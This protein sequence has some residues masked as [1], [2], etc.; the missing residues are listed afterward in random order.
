MSMVTSGKKEPARASR[1][2]IGRPLASR[3]TPGHHSAVGRSGSH[4]SEVQGYSYRHSTIVSVTTMRVTGK[5]AKV[6][7]TRQD[8]PVRHVAKL[9]G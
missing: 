9:A 4:S 1:P 8:S 5:L 2:H 7:A 3:V 6:Q